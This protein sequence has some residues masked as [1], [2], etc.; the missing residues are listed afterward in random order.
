M[1]LFWKQFYEIY[2]STYD[3]TPVVSLGLFIIPSVM[4]DS[5]I[6]NAWL[7]FHSIREV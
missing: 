4:H 6:M 2:W 5:F 7:D 3:K 1:L